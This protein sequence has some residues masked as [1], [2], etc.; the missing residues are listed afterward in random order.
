MRIRAFFHGI[1]SEWVGVPWAEIDLPED[2]TLSD[3]LAEIRRTYGPNMPKQLWNEEQSSF[4]DAVWAMRGQERLVDP[5][6][7]LKNGEEVR[8]FL[9]LAG[10]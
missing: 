9:S 10:G 1:L 2:G 8:F 6:A 5:T 3:L 7:R 4:N